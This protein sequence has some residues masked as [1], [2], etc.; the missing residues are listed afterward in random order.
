MTCKIESGV[1]NFLRFPDLKN[2]QKLIKETTERKIERLS[3]FI[4]HERKR[5]TTEN[6]S[7]SG[8]QNFM[9]ER[10]RNQFYQT[11]NI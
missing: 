10:E 5:R 4:E 6:L 8:A 1:Q 7:A 11:K 3:I 9:T 2:S